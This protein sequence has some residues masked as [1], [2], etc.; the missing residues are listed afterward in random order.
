MV[1]KG[2][3]VEK[4]A[5]WAKGR[6]RYRLRLW[7][8]RHRDER[9]SKGTT[10]IGILR[11]SPV[12]M[13][14]GCTQSKHSIMSKGVQSLCRAPE[15]NVTLCIY[16]TSVKKYMVREKKK[17]SS[18]FFFSLLLLLEYFFFKCLK[19]HL[20]FLD[21]ERF[22]IYLTSNSESLSENKVLR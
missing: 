8:G 13:D 18:L 5:K 7:N 16:Y 22:F 21:D 2:K 12:V 15:T 17:P 20:V 9:Y 11:A 19:G 14:G 3:C 10:V 4:Q 6:G 1:A